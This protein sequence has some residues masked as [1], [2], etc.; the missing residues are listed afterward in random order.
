MLHLGTNSGEESDSKKTKEIFESIGAS[1]RWVGDLLNQTKN[2]TPISVRSRLLPLPFARQKFW[3]AVVEKVSQKKAAQV[4]CQLKKV[5]EEIRET[6]E[7]YRNL[8]ENMNELIFS[9]DQQGCF[10]YISPVVEKL[11]SYQAQE[12]LGQPLA[13][14]VHPDDLLAF[15]Q[16]LKR[17]LSHSVESFEFRIFDKERNIRRMRVS[18]RPLISGGQPVGLTGIMSDITARKWLDGQIQY[19]GFHDK[20]TGLYNRAYFEEELNRLNTSRQLP[21]SVV[22]ADANCLKLVNDAFGHE[23]GDKILTRIALIF[24]ESCRKEDVVAR[25]GGDEFAILL[26]RTS[27]M[28]TAKIV[29]RIKFF[30]SQ[31]SIGWVQLSVALGVGAKEKPS[32]DIQAVLREAE[33]RMYRN[34]LLERKKIRGSFIASLQRVL[35]GKSYETE[36]HCQRIEKLALPVGRHLGFSDIQMHELALLATWHDIGKVAIPGEILRKPDR[37]TE[38]ESQWIRKH[39]EIGYRIAESSNELVSVADAI[40]AHHERW[41]GGGY[42]LGVKGEDIPLIS[43]IVSITDAYDVMTHGR[44]Y[45]KTLDGPVA[46]EELKRKAGSQFDPKLVEVFLKLSPNPGRYE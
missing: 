25:V 39:P 20:L 28:A 14:F 11:I 29:Q 7:K 40:L 42:P 44:H 30:C 10:T 31:K 21:I 5:E 43:R 6:W 34:K 4:A 35:F 45:N 9:L 23:E 38:Q 32:Q 22:V 3:L 1:V 12:I 8:V 13:R 36:E 41:D 19:L 15:V 18:S 37:L 24:R 26:P 33:E 27:A 16:S 17:S 46:R 2:G